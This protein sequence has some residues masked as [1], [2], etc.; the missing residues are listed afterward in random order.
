MAVKFC[1]KSKCVRSQGSLEKVKYGRRICSIV[2]ILC[3]T[4]TRIVKQIMKSGEI[5]TSA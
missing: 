3:D 1:E 4:N 5:Q 2:N